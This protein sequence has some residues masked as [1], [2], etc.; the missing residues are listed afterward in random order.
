[1]NYVLIPLKRKQAQ[2]F[3]NKFHRHHAAPV[4]DIFRIGLACNNKLIGVIMVGRPV[5]RRVDDGLTV[6]VNRCCV[7]EGYKNGCS[8]LYGAA[9]RIAK[10]LGYK[11]IVTYTLDFESGATMRAVGWQLD[12]E[13]RGQKWDQPSRA[14]EKKSRYQNVNKFRW[15]KIFHNHEINL[16]DLISELE[17]K[18]ETNQLRLF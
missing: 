2:K 16:P 1:M 17:N 4:G 14:R 12:H 11:K 6:E 15:S 3:I 18:K 13:V 5:S 9:A 8:L 10:N 7:L